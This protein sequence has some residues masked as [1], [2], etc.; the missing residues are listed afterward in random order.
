VQALARWLALRR[1]ALPL[2]ELFP[3]FHLGVSLDACLGLWQGE[4]L[5]VHALLA[6]PAADAA[7][8]GR[9]AEA[10][11]HEL[12]AVAAQVP[13]R[14]RACVHVLTAD[15]FRADRLREALLE[16]ED[17]HFLSKVLVGRS[18]LALD[19]ASAAYSGRL[20]V[21]PAPQELLAQLGG[22]AE[23]QLPG[24]A[25]ALQWQGRR[26]R[27]Q[28]SLRKLLKPGPAPLTWVLIAANAGAF[29]LQ[30]ALAQ[31]LQAQGLGPGAADF[32]AMIALGANQ[33]LSVLQEG[34]WWRLGTAAFLH[35][36]PLHLL[37][38]M[39]ALY[40]LGGLLERIIGPWRLA[41]FFA[42]AALISSFVSALFLPLGTPSLGASGAILGLAGLLLAPR[43][44]RDPAFPQAL[45]AR[46]FQWLSRPILLIFGLGLGLQALDLGIQ[47]DNAAHAGGLLFGLALGYLYPSFLVPAKHRQG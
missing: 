35:G 33:S 26:L 25:E 5:M 14:I 46:L 9:R 6:D 39:A 24:E 32:A 36:G 29:G 47:F 7:E 30:L 31:R 1:Q 41:A 10:L 34:Q 15:R 23:A 12:E 42:V 11:R 13:G 17:G 37:M 45:A 20:P 27:E 28:R 43:F 38:N 18:V 3:G 44:R 16:H 21:E 19:D 2:G 8:A 22:S 4:D 40:S